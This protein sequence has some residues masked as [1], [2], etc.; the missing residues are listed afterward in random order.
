MLTL[1]LN[2]QYPKLQRYGFL[3]IIRLD[4]ELASEY[5]NATNFEMASMWNVI[6][7][8]IKMAF[9]SRYQTL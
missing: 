8:N 9:Y 3:F 2:V 7:H 4:I 6:A 1:A 5:G